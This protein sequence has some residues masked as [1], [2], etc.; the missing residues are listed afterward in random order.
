MKEERMRDGKKYK[1]VQE[2]NW[3]FCRNYDVLE[4]EGERLSV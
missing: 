3:W 2:K 1:E 4:K